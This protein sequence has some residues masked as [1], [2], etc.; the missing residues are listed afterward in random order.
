MAPEPLLRAQR[1]KTNRGLMIRAFLSSTTAKV[2]D[3]Y[4][5]DVGAYLNR[6]RLKTR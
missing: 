4:Q 3:R 1:A 5:D 6:R 2:P